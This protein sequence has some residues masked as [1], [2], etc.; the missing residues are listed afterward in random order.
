L[1]TRNPIGFRFSGVQRQQGS[2]SSSLHRSERSHKKESET[3]PVSLLRQERCRLAKTEQ[4][5]NP[6][7][8]PSPS[9]S[10]SQNFLVQVKLPIV[11][12][13]RPNWFL[14][15]P[16]TQ[17]SCPRASQVRP[18]PGSR[19]ALPLG[20]LSGVVGRARAHATRTA[21]ADTSKVIRR[22]IASI[23]Q[24]SFAG[25]EATGRRKE[26]TYGALG[27]GN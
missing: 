8:T 13:S 25:A 17:P 26:L 9:E 4:K 7:V 12:K 10:V 1:V 23:G 2:P 21:P 18:L 16:G 14:A 22:V 15:A 19:D 24:S 6:F 11:L 5:T 20:I 3:I 27:C